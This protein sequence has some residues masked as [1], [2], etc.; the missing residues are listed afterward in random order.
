MA[1]PHWEGTSAAGIYL[2]L[3]CGGAA[4]RASFS[5]PAAAAASLTPVAAASL[6]QRVCFCVVIYYIYIPIRRLAGDTVLCSE[7]KIQIFII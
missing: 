5:S 3:H 2:S 1:T 4:R 7:V 6:R